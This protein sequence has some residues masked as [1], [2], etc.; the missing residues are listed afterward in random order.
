MSLR[1]LIDEN[2][3]HEVSD[4]LRQNHDTKILPAG[5]KD[6]AIAAVADAERRVLVTHDLDFANIFLYPP[7]K[8]AGIIILR[9]L[10]PTAPIIIQALTNLLT[11][12]P[13]D[14]YSGKLIILEP[15]GFRIWK[16]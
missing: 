4:F 8:Y 9:I 10:P 6:D 7:S 12:L 15:G 5:T 3:R 13:E 16:E 11:V 14:Q 1:F 2:V